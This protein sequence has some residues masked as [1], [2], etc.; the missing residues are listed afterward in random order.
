MIVFL[1]IY[2]QYVEKSKEE[3]SLPTYTDVS[4]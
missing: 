1:V 2:D 3:H 4:P